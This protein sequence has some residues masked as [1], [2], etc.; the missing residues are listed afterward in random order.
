MSK[1]NLTKKDA[2]FFLSLAF[3]VFIL[4][5][6]FGDWFLNYIAPTAPSNDKVMVMIFTTACLFMPLVIYVQSK[7]YKKKIQRKEVFKVMCVV[8]CSTV[9]PFFFW[10][11]TPKWETITPI[12]LLVF[13]SSAYIFERIFNRKNGGEKP[14]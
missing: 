6:P 9:P 10:L 1:N 4:V 8:C 12:S 13:I 14:T 2:L 7:I 5:V 11:L 3:I